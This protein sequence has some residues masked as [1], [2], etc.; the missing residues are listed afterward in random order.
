MPLITAFSTFSSCDI[1]VL[2]ESPTCQDV[3]PLLQGQQRSGLSSPDEGTPRQQQ[4]PQQQQEE[5]GAVVVPVAGEGL[6]PASKYGRK[7]SAAAVPP[8]GAPAW[9][10]ACNSGETGVSWFSS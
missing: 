5:E 7:A 3:Q 4:P 6:G 1:P 8:L 9:S 2:Q 10:L